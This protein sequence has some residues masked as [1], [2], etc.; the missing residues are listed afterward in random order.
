MQFSFQCKYH[1]KTCPSDIGKS[2]DV[3]QTVGPEHIGWQYCIHKYNKA[4]K[5]YTREQIITDQLARLNQTQ[6]AVL[7]LSLSLYIQYIH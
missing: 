1:V 2:R 7:S 6:K 5:Y 4:K 3:L